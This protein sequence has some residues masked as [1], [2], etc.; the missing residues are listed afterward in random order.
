MFQTFKFSDPI[1]DNM[2]NITPVDR[3]RK[4]R[5]ASSPAFSTGRLR[6]MNFLIEDCAVVTAQHLKEEAAK[7]ED[8]DI[9]HC[10]P[11]HLK[12]TWAATI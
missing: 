6:K 5:P 3:W 11:N 4:I 1:L 10:I 2:M 9:K 12:I 7:E 8:I